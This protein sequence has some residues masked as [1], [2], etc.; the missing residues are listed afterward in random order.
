MSG[1]T[2]RRT[3][4][5]TAAATTAAAPEPPATTKALTSRTSLDPYD[6]LTGAR[7]ARLERNVPGPLVANRDVVDLL[8]ALHLAPAF[9]QETPVPACGAP[10]QLVGVRD[11]E[12][13]TL[14]EGFL[15]IRHAAKGSRQTVPTSWPIS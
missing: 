3:G 9:G 14:D 15:V 2:P 4:S 7:E 5:T 6:F 8:L 11:L 1:L 10:A 12:I 13:Q